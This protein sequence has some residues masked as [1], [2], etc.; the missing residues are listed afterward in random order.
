MIGKALQVDAAGQAL[1]TLTF[2]DQA[3]FRAAGFTRHDNKPTPG[4]HGLTGINE[5][6]PEGLEPT[7]NP[8]IVNTSLCQPLLHQRRPHAATEAEQGTVGVLLCEGGPGLGS[9][10]AQVAGYQLMAELHCSILALLLVTASYSLPLEV[11]HK[12][13]IGGGGQAAPGKFNRGP[14]INQRCVSAK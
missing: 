4:I 10:R 14:G 12:R 3:G 2:I 13:Q 6:A 7:P 9:R 1:T 11:V 8:W 5:P